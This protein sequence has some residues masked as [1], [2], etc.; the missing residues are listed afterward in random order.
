M[1]CESGAAVVHN[2]MA[3]YTKELVTY[4]VRIIKYIIQ[5]DRYFLNVLRA[6]SFERAGCTETTHI[7]W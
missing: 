7:E 4:E 2:L 3:V 1:R 5:Q 6:S